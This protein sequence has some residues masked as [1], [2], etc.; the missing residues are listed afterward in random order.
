LGTH[1]QV[2]PIN[3]FSRVMAQTMRTSA[4]MC[5]FGF[6][7]YHSPF[8]GSNPPK[9]AASW[10]WKNRN[11]AVTVLLMTAKFDTVMHIGLLHAIYPST[12]EFLKIQDGGRWPS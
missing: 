5:L 4:G 7:W 12:F 9:M 1:L 10:K 2:R 3:G 8:W 11:I 6:C